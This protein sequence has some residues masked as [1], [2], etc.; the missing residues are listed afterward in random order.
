MAFLKAGDHCLMPDSVYGP[1]RTFCDTLLRGWAIETTYYDPAVDE[2]GM[3]AL[4]RPN[5]RVV[6]TE[7]PGSHSF[8]VQDVPAIAAV[9]RARGIAT[10]VDNT[11]ATPLYLQTLRHGVDISVCVGTKYLGGHSDVMLGAATANA[12]LRRADW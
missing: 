5:T 7:S 11:W 2:A 8:E 9:A 3:R 6:Y 4:I 10:I 1:A 12:A